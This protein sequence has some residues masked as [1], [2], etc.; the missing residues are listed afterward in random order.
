MP[1]ITRAADSEI[2]AS[3]FSRALSD[4][5][6]SQEAALA[7]APADCTDE[8]LEA[9]AATATARSATIELQVQVDALPPDAVLDEAMLRVHP[10]VP[11]WLPAPFQRALGATDS[12]L[13]A[14]IHEYAGIA[15]H[16]PVVLTTAAAETFAT[17]LTDFSDRVQQQ[18]FVGRGLRLLLPVRPPQFQA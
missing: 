3:A 11:A 10:A 14:G 16:T 8:L 4:A 2:S 5:I 15:T 1:Q 6:S 18:I 7:R 12:T 9:R 13:A 17:V